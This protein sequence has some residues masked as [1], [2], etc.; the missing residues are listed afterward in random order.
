[1]QNHEIHLLSALVVVL[2]AVCNNSVAV[3]VRWSD[4]EQEGWMDGIGGVTHVGSCAR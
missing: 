3:D 1:M 4:D 2:R